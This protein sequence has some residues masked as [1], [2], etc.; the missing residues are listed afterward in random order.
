MLFRSS[1]HIPSCRRVAAATES[2]EGLSRSASSAASGWLPLEMNMY[3]SA[4]SG[5]AAPSSFRT[6]LSSIVTASAVI[7]SI[8]TYRF[9][10]EKP[11]LSIVAYYSTVS[12]I[13]QLPNGEEFHQFS[14]EV[15]GTPQDI[16][17]PFPFLN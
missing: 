16:V 4:A 5:L 15:F 17:F 2:L 12:S 10:G 1:G 13:R 11:K 8:L 3:K 6:L 14:R 9:F 7:V